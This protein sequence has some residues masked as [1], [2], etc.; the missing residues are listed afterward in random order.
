MEIITYSLKGQQ[1]IEFYDQLS[2]FTDKI[3]T[4][5]GLYFSKDIAAYKKYLGQNF[6]L[7]IRSN[8]EYL[9]EFLTAGIFLNKYAAYAMSAGYMSTSLLYGLYTIRKNFSL[10]KPAID[11]LRGQLSHVFLYSKTFK[12]Y[13][14][15][16]PV[17][18]KLI[19]WLKATGEFEEEI[20]RIRSWNL[21]YHSLP[22]EKA[23]N[24]INKSIAFSRYFQEQGILHLGK[25]TYNVS[26]FL[27]K[28]HRN[29]K[30]REDYLFCGR[31]EAEYHL[32]M[33]GAEVLNRLLRKDFNNTREKAV[34][35]PTCMSN[36]QN[37]QCKASTAGLRMKCNSCSKNCEINKVQ[38]SLKK[39]GVETYLIP[40]SSN[41]SE[42]LKHWKNQDTTGLVGVACVLNLLKGG[43][44]MQNLNIPSQCVF[45][46][47]CG[48]KKH[49]HKT[50]IPTSINFKQLEKI[51]SID[52]MVLFN[53]KS[54]EQ[55][56]PVENCA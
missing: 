31:S 15:S 50:G 33:F 25:Y 40:H 26:N 41:F 6:K 9:I 22:E 49:W 13:T 29:Y 24:I 56:S 48:C 23:L 18:A 32:N 39:K 1:N 7:D 28:E 5:A 34:L 19:R 37:G 4:E 2:V 8:E 3:L 21:Y 43:Y 20:K 10:L 42:F 45:L 36:L 54:K 52:K 55:L 16:L 30:Q 53:E 11:F 47:H 35:L 38:E 17:F 44:E 51:L 12:T 27:E 14:Y 46:E